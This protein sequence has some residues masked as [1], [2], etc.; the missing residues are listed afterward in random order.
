MGNFNKI[1][2]FYDS[3]CP[4]C[5]KVKHNIEKLDWFH[6]IE[7][8]S[9]RNN[10]IKEIDIPL[11]QL[12]KEMYCLNIKNGKIT[13]GIDAIASIIARLPLVMIFWIPLKLS[14]LL[15]IGHVIYNYIAQTRKIIPV[16]NCEDESCKIPI[17]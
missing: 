8:R 13:K 14:S 10:N 16:N 9:I 5:T 17:K 7:I 2:V 1:I 15:R 11:E 3:W 6:L 4:V 12:E